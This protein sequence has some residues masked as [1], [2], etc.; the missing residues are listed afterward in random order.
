[1]LRTLFCFVAWI[2]VGM[3]HV[4]G[5]DFE[6]TTTNASGAG[7]Y[8]QAV[9][10]SNDNPGPDRIVFN[11]PGDEVHVIQPL[12]SLPAFTEPIVVDGYSQPGAR[13]NTL[14]NGINA[15]L[16]IQLDGTDPFRAGPGVLLSGGSSTV[17]GLSITRFSTAV[18]LD[19]SSNRVSGCFIGT[20]PSGLNPMGNGEAFYMQ[21][22]GPGPPVFDA[23][24]L[25]ASCCH[26][27]GGTLGRRSRG[28]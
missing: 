3:G 9:E 5:A 6:V 28:I 23:T 16:L 10:D 26:V 18:W 11:I 22:L 25:L 4:W 8:R 19:S 17:R 12:T 24:Y 21:R 27:I 1:M 15:R 20:D 14:S 13:V 7:S 2:G